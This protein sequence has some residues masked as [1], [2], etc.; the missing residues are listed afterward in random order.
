MP[1]PWT[2]PRTKQTPG[3]RTFH[4]ERVARLVLVRLVPAIG[5]QDEPTLENLNELVV[6]RVVDVH[7]PR[8]RFVDT[9][10]D[11]ASVEDVRAVLDGLL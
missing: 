4:D 2:T 11:L 6:F 5:H 7:L 3:I 1:C 10:H 8:R 9:H